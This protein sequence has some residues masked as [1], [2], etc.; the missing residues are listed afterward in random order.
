MAT[1]KSI[2]IVTGT[3]KGASG[4]SDGVPLDLEA[5]PWSVT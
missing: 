2:A 3:G 4:L 5:F 1:A